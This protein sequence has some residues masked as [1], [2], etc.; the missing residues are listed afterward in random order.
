MNE[1][2]GVGEKHIDS[3]KTLERARGHILNVRWHGHI[4][5]DDKRF[6]GELGRQCFQFVDRAGGQRQLAAAFRH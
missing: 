3:A 4:S 2:T 6:R 5:P 1:D